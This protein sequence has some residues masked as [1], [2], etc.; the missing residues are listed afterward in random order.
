MRGAISVISTQIE[1]DYKIEI[2]KRFWKE[3]VISI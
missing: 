1:K 3:N 2:Y